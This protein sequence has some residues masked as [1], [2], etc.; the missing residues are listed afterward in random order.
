MERWE[1]CP[2]VISN[3]ATL[4]PWGS[5]HHQW[6]AI[7]KRAGL[8]GVRIHDLLH[9]FASNLVNSG[10]S[11]YKVGRLLGHSQ[12]KTTQ[13]Y[14]HL[15]D[16]CLWRPWRRRQTRRVGSVG[17]RAGRARR[18]HTQLSGLGCCVG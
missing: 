16:A 1:G 12:V 10:R 7:W 8:D 6:S 2:Y 15:S 18:H 9:S 17:K 3:P 11:I 4:R 14:A 5:L 13:R